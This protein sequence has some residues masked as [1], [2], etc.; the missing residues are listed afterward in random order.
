MFVQL[1]DQLQIVRGE[2]I[3]EIYLPTDRSDVGEF[4]GLTPTAVRRA[5]R[6]LTTQGAMK[7]WNRRYVR[8]VDRAA[9]EK[10][11]GDPVEQFDVGLRGQIKN[12]H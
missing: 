4:T 5:F 11:A 9:F 6:S 12:R 3:A 8:N 2:Q 1:I 7:I 10:I